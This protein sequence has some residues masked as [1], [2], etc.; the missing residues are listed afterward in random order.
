MTTAEEYKKLGN[1]AFLA[2]NY[3]TAIENFT[4][5]IEIDPNNHV[6]FSNRSGCY[7][8]LNIWQKALEDGEASIRINP[9][10]VKGYSRVG[11]ALFKLGK[12][13]E[14]TSVIDKG[15]ELDPNNELLRKDKEAIE[16]AS[17][18]P[19]MNEMMGLF[20]KPEIQKLMKE[21]PQLINQFLQNPEMLKNPQMMQ[22]MAGL[23]SKGKTAQPP[24]E[25]TPNPT[26][27]HN[28]FTKESNPEPKCERPTEK[29]EKKLGV[30]ETS[31]NHAN[32]L[33]KKR[34]FE[35]AIQNYRLC[36][37]ECSTDLLIR[38]NIAACHIEL[39][40]FTQAI[41][42]INE[43]LDM[44]KEMGFE[45]RVP[46]TY[47]KLLG[48]K[49]RV[50]FLEQKFDE[51]LDLYSQALLEDRNPLLEDQQ[52]EVLKAKKKRDEEAY[53]DTGLSD[54]HREKGNT[55]FS[56]GDFG[57]ANKEYEE[58]LRR[59]PRD[60]RIHNNIAM[61]FI[62][63]MKF[64]EAMKSVEKALELDPKFIKALL[65]KAAIH[66]SLKE[67]HKAIDT[68]KRIN[69]LEPGNKEASE[70]IAATQLK[71]SQSMTEGN[72]EDRV[73]RAMSDPEIASIMTDP[74]V[75]IALEQMQT[76][77]KNIMEYMNDK[78]LGP[79][80]QKLIQAGIIKMG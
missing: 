34:D 62:K 72:D 76:N 58:A 20:N 2:K 53:L 32:E 43:A 15:L 57:N 69:E 33:Y 25:P 49:A 35:G 10:F 74:M 19:Q 45:Q 7:A 80:I 21:N 75:R 13:E 55:L 73:K 14:A 6:Y 11:L 66:N 67:Y 27:N 1:D 16:A 39:K 22:M 68:Y 52:K 54:I 18:G 26:H 78:T 40:Q 8:S 46:A 42:V 30:F 24:S 37:E 79:K 12:H 17:A 31:K 38:N 23:F 61:C 9:S 70:G 41:E 28:N 63:M 59:N 65:R 51:S 64:N 4:R 50:M 44:Y 71:I 48:R 47:A 36:L 77:P 5:A 56:Q 29:P 60:P 3:E